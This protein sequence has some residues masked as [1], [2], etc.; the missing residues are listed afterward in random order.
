MNTGH[1]RS[2]AII[3][4]CLMLG[5]L[6]GCRGV[7]IGIDL[8]QRWPHQPPPAGYV[9]LVRIVNCTPYFLSAHIRQIGRVSEIP[10]GR[11]AELFVP[12]THYRLPMDVVVTAWEFGS[13]R[14]SADRRFEL[15]FPPASVPEWDV[16]ISELR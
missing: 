8:H 14:G 12:R 11:S 1:V 7:S 16:R 9:A 13:P 6:G 10:P 3:A 4:A 2:A 15:W 5:G